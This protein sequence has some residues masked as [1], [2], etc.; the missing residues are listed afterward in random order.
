MATTD[1]PTDDTVI[2][3]VS[4]GE[5]L[6]SP[7]EVSPGYRA[8][9][10]R[11]LAVFVDSELAGTAGLVPFIN[12]APGLR[13]RVTAARIVAEKFD[14]A[15]QVLD[16]MAPF[17]VN[18][19]LYVR[20]H[21]WASRL[22][23]DLDLGNRRIGGDKRLNVFH[24]PLEGWLDAIIL[25]MLMGTA[26]ATQLL[27]LVDSSYAPL[28]AVMAAIVAREAAH[29]RS[30]ETALAQAIGRHGT[31][32]AAQGAVDYWFPRVVHTF[33]RADSQHFERSRAL[34]LRRR[35]NAEGLNRW[36]TDIHP[37]LSALGLSRPVG[38]A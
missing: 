28:R 5:I 7:V 13:E 24:A 30:G 3:R 14:H 18:P 35:T 37:R 9:L 20:A 26:V 17:G 4:R 22:D 38:P 36:I 1:A 16:I 31:P 19:T 34:G 25:N 2:D 23:R 6:E 15:Q 21:C 33:G 10:M 12:S 32:S 8:E 29:A 27:D 11:V